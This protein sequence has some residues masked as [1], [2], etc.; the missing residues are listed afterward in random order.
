[1]TNIKPLVPNTVVYRETYAVDL[2]SASG[3][4]FT[5]S[6]ANGET[7]AI[8]FEQLPNNATLVCT[9]R[10]AQRGRSYRGRIYHIGLTEGQVVANTVV[11]GIITSLSLAYAQLLNTANFGGCELA[12]LSR[13][14]A[15]APRLIGVATPVI[16]TLFA[17]PTIDSQRRRLPGRGR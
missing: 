16:D 3:G 1:V 2:S 9:L 12:V 11:P 14:N 7:G 10:T 8:S 15:N 5:A 6:G 4:V 13:Y 17:D